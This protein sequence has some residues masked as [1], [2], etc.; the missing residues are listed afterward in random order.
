MN[1][2]NR[3]E[4]TELLYDDLAPARAGE[5]RRHVETCAECRAQIESWR[6]VRR[7]LAEWRLP[8][9]REQRPAWQPG[10]GWRLA[11]LGAAAAVFVLAGFG[12][13]R[14]SAPRPADAVAMRE[15]ITSQ[16]REELRAELARFAADQE[17]RQGAYH[18]ALVEAVGQ[19]EVRRMVDY[20]ALRRDVETVALRARDEFTS[21]RQDILR[22]AVADAPGRDAEPK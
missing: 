10:F 14:L 21:T 16:M 15:V 22:L 13:A 18:E 3:E 12:L 6:E 11:A 4:L 19:L 5:V 17:A 20:A 1:H 2:P 8:G 7:A 9:S